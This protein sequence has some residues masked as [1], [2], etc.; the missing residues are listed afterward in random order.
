MFS[1][2]FPFWKRTQSRSQASRSVPQKP[3]FYRPTVEILE[4][5]IAPATRVWTGATSTLWSTSANW[6][7]G[8]TPVAGDT[9]VFPTGAANLTNT[10]DFAP[11]TRFQS[12]I[13]SGSGYSVSGQDI[14]LG[15]GGIVN[16]SASNHFL[17]NVAAPTN[18]ANLLMTSYAG[19]TLILGGTLFGPGAS[20][21]LIKSGS[22][23]VQVFGVN[24]SSGNTF[25]RQGTLGAG[26]NLAFGTGTVIVNGN[27]TVQLLGGGFPS[28]RLILTGSATTGAAVLAGQGDWF[29]PIN[30][31]GTSRFDVSNGNTLVLDGVI[32]GSAA[33]Q[34][35]GGGKL[36]LTHS[37]TYTGATTISAGIL[38]ITNGSALGGTAAGTTVA[39]GATL[40]I[41]NGITVAEPITF[42]SGS[43][44]ENL[45]GQ[46]ALTAGITLAGGSPVFQVDADQLSI[47]GVLSGAGGLTKSGPGDMQLA[48][49]NTYTGV[50]TVADGTLGVQTTTSLGTAAAG[51]VV[52]N[53][54]TVVD[55]LSAAVAEPLT[56]NGDGFDN[57]GAL[58]GGNGTW[59][60]PITLADSSTIGAA[61]GAIF[62]L[63]GVISGPATADLAF[64]GPGTITLKGT[65]TYL[66]G[67]TAEA[68][69][70][71]VENASGL[72]SSSNGTTV[73]GNAILQIGAF[74]VAE[75]LFL[76]S[77]ATL[78]NNSGL[79]TV[80]GAI[81]LY[82][83]NPAIF[84]SAGTELKITGAINDPFAAGFMIAGG[85][86]RLTGTSTD[87]GTVTDSGT[88]LVDGTL[89]T[90]SILVSSGVLGGKGS[91][92]TL[93]ITGSGSAALTPSR[94]GLTINDAIV[95]GFSS[96]NTTMG[97]SGADHLIL[98]NG[99]D[100]N[101]TSMT[102]NFSFDAGFTPAIGASFTL[103]DNQG[104]VGTPFPGWP[105]GGV[106]IFPS[107]RFL[108]TYTGGTSGEDVVF[109]RV[110]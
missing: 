10:N 27:A 9:L 36:E 6:V 34:K 91:I 40:Q 84:Q 38:L 76:D 7:G 107:G 35:T 109:K 83:P 45:S 32:S 65:N 97:T 48:N 73:V 4:A 70:V 11:G 66:G 39:G 25:V 64:A 98:R 62:Q 41:Q 47:A 69:T 5:R 61:S 50:T 53:G 8:A 78:R 31:L 100:V 55:E 15:T 75:P 92:T 79:T 82:G 2:R 103:I 24:N 87:I 102:L 86:V 108:I 58:F 14:T 23:T 1:L 30:L 56:L 3:R 17:C 43:T 106:N 16:K 101:L 95:T 67:T 90:S 46:N 105:E 52:L 63:T 104:H 12:I 26:N 89:I 85:T 74:T 51:T 22:G 20:G 21:Q 110:P 13:F 28:N 18:S 60:G 94:T 44:L 81:I 88:L 72:G 54:A 19:A 80:S 77:N 96:F 71:D 37:N 99:A 42:N 93:A 68:G 29:G 49:S 57:T 33:M 59:S